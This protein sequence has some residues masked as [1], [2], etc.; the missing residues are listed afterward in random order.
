MNKIGLFLFCI[1]SFYTLN[2]QEENT[3]TSNKEDEYYSYTIY[4]QDTLILTKD[5]AY[6]VSIKSFEAYQKIKTDLLICLSKREED[7]TT[8]KKIFEELLA[9]IS[10]LEE[11]I[12][13][14]HALTSETF[15]TTQ[16]ELKKIMNQLTTD[17]NNLQDIKIAIDKASK[18][19]EQLQKQLFKSKRNLFWLRFGD[20][21]LAAAIGIAIGL[22]L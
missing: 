21:S 10:K 2:A 11:M 5:S 19:L 22:I 14:K 15:K 16:E 3:K 6:V 4:K 18:E 8:N 12:N 20:V 13:N 1:L 7:I 17:L 9:N